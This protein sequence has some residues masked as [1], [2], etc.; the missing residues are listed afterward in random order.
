MFGMLIIIPSILKLHVNYI[1]ASFY[2]KKVDIRESQLWLWEL[3][4][5]ILQK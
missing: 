1:E 4:F 2:Q 3:V 5:S